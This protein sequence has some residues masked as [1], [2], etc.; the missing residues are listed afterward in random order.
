MKEQKKG[1]TA[2][3]KDK[4][5]ALRWV[6]I[7]TTLG[8]PVLAGPAHHCQGQPPESMLVRFIFDEI[9]TYRTL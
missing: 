7:I 3:L 2:T 9:Y 1:S 8:F 5:L 6:A 4:P